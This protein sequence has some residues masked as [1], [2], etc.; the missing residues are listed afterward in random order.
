MKK[1]QI[2]NFTESLYYDELSNGLKVY[3]VPMKN[4]K[5]FSSMIVTKYGGRDI[6]FS[7]D[8]NSYNTPSGIAH[9]LEHK[10]FERDIDPFKFY[11][12]FG[13]DVNAATS[14]DY[15]CYY[16]IGSKCFKKSL[17]YLLNWIQKLDITDEQ[18]EKEKG[19]ILEEAS[20]YKDNPSRVIYNKIKENIFVNDPKK[21]K[22][23]GTDEDIKSITKNDLD[24]CYNNFYIPNNM[25][26]LVA[27][28]VNPTEVF[29]IADSETKK[30]KKK[31]TK[32][33]PIY[34]KEPDNVAKQYE[35][36]YMN[37][38]VPKV[39]LSY[40][41]NK[42]SF[43]VLN[44]TPFELDLYLHFLIN[45]S[46]GVTSEIRQEWIKKELFTDAFYRI[47]E[48]ESHYVIEFH[49][50]SNKEEELLQSL[51][52][53]LHNLELDQDSFEREK[54]IWIANEIRA[55]ENPTNTLYSILDDLLDYNCFISN[56]IECIKNLS[57]STL[58]KVRDL[59]NYDN[60]IIIKIL[61]LQLQD[62]NSK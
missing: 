7:I 39:N 53:Y 30:F 59:I 5:N 60:E 26:L 58:L 56:K 57:F 44:L 43:K 3:V 38:G 55:I 23:I 1:I 37:I 10:M 9:F 54:K 51:K 21:N 35:E 52:K 4:K 33:I 19:I 34:G 24:L 14:D 17:K 48:I 28:N 36:I 62:K 13:T 25:Y 16:F 46:L 45:I 15:T 2:N 12:K 41:I 47:S 40:K 8:G 61:P 11:G 27:G 18:V 6:N 22:V 31:E 29:Q 32:G 50:N 42:D 49:A 20:M